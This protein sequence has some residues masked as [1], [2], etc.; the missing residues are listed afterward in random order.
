MRSTTRAKIQIAGLYGAAGLL[1]IIL[2]AIFRQPPVLW[3]W[4]MFGTIFGVL[5]WRT[6]EVNDR[7]SASPTVMVMLTGAVVFGAE[8]A[9]LGIASMTV[10]GAVNR[11]DLAERRWF[12]P[13]ANFGQMALAGAVSGL[14][15]EQLM[16]AGELIRNE[17]PQL[18]A[19]TALAAVVHAAVN[20][21]LVVLAIRFVYGRRDLRPWVGMRSLLPSYLVMG[22]LGGL[23]G[24]AYLL[25]GPV[26]LPL[27]LAVFFIGH[28]NFASYSTVREAHETTLR[29][30][31]KALE[32]KDPYTRGHTERVAY[33]AQIIGEEMGM[34]GDRLDRI[35]IA[36]LIHDIGKLAVPQSLIRKRGRLESDEFAVMQDH[37]HIVEDIL[38]EVDFL[39]PMVELASYHHSRYDGHGY[40]GSG[41]RPG[42]SPPVESCILGVA[43]AFDAMTSTRSYRSALSQEYALAE[44]RRGAGTQFSPDA[45]AALMRALEKSGERYGSP[46]LHD[47]DEAR[48]LAEDSGVAALG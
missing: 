22:A 11:T 38:A 31:I 17:L 26:T 36:A 24:A 9:A 27:I 23:L 42:E 13:I 15:L 8:A 47:E 34:R 41:H 4:L 32:A 30:F 37:A 19:A 39:R 6:V 5:Q 40:G 14:L 10:F 45:V 29:G 28:L 1:S 46:F 16:P 43:D 44:L 25:V 48:R 35:R 7:L 18:A 2:L 33:F 21:G 12:Q 20:L 3:E